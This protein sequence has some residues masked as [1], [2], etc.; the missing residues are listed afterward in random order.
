M[1]IGGSGKCKSRLKAA[2][3][4]PGYIDGVLGSRTRDAL[5]RYQASQGLPITGQLDETTR[6][7]LLAGDRVRS[8]SAA[9]QES[10][11]KALP[12]GDYKNLSSLAQ[13]PDYFPCLG[14][15]YVDP[16]T[17]PA[18]PFLAYDRQGNLVSSVYMIPLRDLRAGKAFNVSTSAKAKVDHVDI[19]NNNGHPM[20]PDPHYHIVLSYIAPAQV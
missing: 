19:Y 4:D 18:G 16:A 17:L 9:Q 5:C 3:F 8:G 10:W 15:L 14:T 6:Q 13:L 2:G 1:A 12:G 7:I 11:L 20:V